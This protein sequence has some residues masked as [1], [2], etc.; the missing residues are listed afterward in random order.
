MSSSSP[1]PGSSEPE[2]ESEVS[3]AQPATGFPDLPE[4][5]TRRCFVCL[6]DEPIASLPRDWSTPCRCS[7][8]G[9]HE[10]LLDWV[11]D[12]ESQQKALVC[13]QCKAKIRV[14]E[15]YDPLVHLSDYLNKLLTTWSPTILLSFVGSGALVGSALYGIEAIE[16]F[17]G[18]E[19]ATRFIIKDVANQG[20]EGYLRSLFPLAAAEPSINFAH[21]FVLPFI[22]PGLILNRLN[23]GGIFAIPTSLLVKSLLSHLACK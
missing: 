12:L 9:H 1:P 16:I 22:G 20:F 13:P 7:L 19:A 23:L 5:N 3:S 15:K 8:E 2:P 14:T 11:A 18:P 10:C 4:N 17:A 21:F 6:T